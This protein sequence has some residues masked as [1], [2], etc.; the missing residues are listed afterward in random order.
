MTSP[1]LQNPP[2]PPILESASTFAGK[3][4]LAAVRVSKAQWPCSECPS[5]SSSSSSATRPCLLT[6]TDTGTA[7]HNAKVSASF[8]FHARAS[9]ILCRL[10]TGKTRSKT[11]T[12]KV[13]QML[14]QGLPRNDT[15]RGIF[16]PVVLISPGNLYAP[17]ICITTDFLAEKI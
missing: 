11:N 8:G 15:S 4:S 5:S 1:S 13:L 17:F 2:L 7:A 3:G 14:P 6:P 12:S 9:S 10:L 16:E